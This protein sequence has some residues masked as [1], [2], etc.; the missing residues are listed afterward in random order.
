MI[1]AVLN[2]LQSLLFIFIRHLKTNAYTP[3]KQIR[4]ESRTDLIWNKSLNAR[5]AQQKLEPLRLLNGSQICDGF[6][7]L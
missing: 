3:H 7:R 2:D 6:Q 1:K 5:G 4:C